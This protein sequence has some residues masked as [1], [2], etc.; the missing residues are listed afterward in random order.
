MLTGGHSEKYSLPRTTEGAEFDDRESAKP[1][2]GGSLRFCFAGLCGRAGAEV[3]QANAGVQSA[4]LLSPTINENWPSY[5]GDY[6]GRRYS[7][8]TQINPGNV[9]QLR[10]Q[11]VF[12]SRNAGTLE[13]TPVVMNGVM[14]ITASND[15]YA[16]NSTD[17]RT[18]W[19]YSRPVS[20]GLVDD[21]AGHINRGVALLGT[22]LYTETDNAH[23]FVWTRDPGTC[24]GMSPM[25]TGTGIMELPALR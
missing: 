7:S 10:A 16:L 13:V 8:L 15:V 18:L 14:Y 17:G 2:E 3:E 4:Q 19:H 22:R 24:C 1:M 12:H 11:W 9:G 5:N 23:L 21:A 25:R 20:S 6:S